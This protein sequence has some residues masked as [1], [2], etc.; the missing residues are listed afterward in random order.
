MNRQRNDSFPSE[1]EKNGIGTTKSRKKMPAKITPRTPVSMTRRFPS[2]LAK[3]TA[4]SE[5]Y[6][7]PIAVPSDAISTIHPSAVRPKNGAITEIAKINKRV[8]AGVLYFGCRTPNH[9]GRMDDF[10]IRY[11]VR[12]VAR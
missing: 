2:R 8:R 9:A 10:A 3:R 11:S 4:A 7:Y 1:Q 5:V 12:L 6:P